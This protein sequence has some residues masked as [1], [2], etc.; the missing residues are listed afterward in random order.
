MKSLV[1]L[2]ALLAAPSAFGQ[3]T[4]GLPA[5]VSNVQYR[6]MATGTDLTT[7]TPGVFVFNEPVS[8]ENYWRQNHR[9]PGPAMERNF[10]Q[11]WRLVAIH[12][13]DRPTGGYALGV[14]KI[15]RRIDKATIF[16]IEAIPS[17]GSR[18]S[19]GTTS[20]WVLLQVE[21][22]AFDFELQ[23]RQLPGYASGGT[24]VAGGSTVQIGG[25]TVTFGPGY[26]SGCDH[27]D[28]CGRGSCRCDRGDRGCDCRGSR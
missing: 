3:L 8:W 24:S 4:Y 26:S 23:T 1:G 28:H 16:G 20:P 2:V 9:G 21:R 13:G 17:R 10:F 6:T 15:V 19:R 12:A 7:N 25:A 27:C 18:P 11:K 5:N 14:Q 22:G